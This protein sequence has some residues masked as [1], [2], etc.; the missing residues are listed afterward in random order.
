MPALDAIGR[1]ARGVA[2]LAGT[3]VGLAT[4]PRHTIDTA[5]RVLEGAGMLVGELLRPADPASPLK[6][7]FVPAKQVAW[8][9]PVAIRD[10]K[11]IGAVSG[12]K[13]NDVL[14]A[15][16]TGALRTYL[17]GR[18]VDVDHTTVRAMVPVDLRP[19]ERAGELGNEFGL[20]ILELA[21]PSGRA[22]Q[23]LALTKARMDTLKR[24]PEP[25]AM[26]L[27]LDLFGRVPKALED[28]ATSL[29]GSKAS[30]VMTNVVGPRE[31]LCLAGVPVERMMF[32][33]PHPGEQ[34]GMGISIMSY[35]GQATLAV[36][37]DARLVPDPESITAA[38]ER[39]FEAMLGAA[40][41]RPA[42]AAA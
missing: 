16:M 10:V 42:K 27:L 24:S 13:V 6:G 5:A 14:V 31:R 29:Y 21:V 4:H 22:A 12:A 33:V 2:A 19:P 9:K 32:W 38:F 37:A 11:V 1:A 23:R 41:R 7:E 3:A 26:R 40:R 17:K 36:I 39:E 34:L 30:V 8:S 25:L 28:V 18:G 35:R 20:V 15:A